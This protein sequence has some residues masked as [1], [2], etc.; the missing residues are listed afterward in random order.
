[1]VAELKEV[2]SKVEQLQD[3][4]QKQIA[5]LLGEELQ[6]ETTFQNTQDQLSNLAQEA[7]AE[8][9]AGKTNNEDW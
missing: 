5:K 1:M 8:Y 2:I 4:E 3:E 6:W 7:L 9:K